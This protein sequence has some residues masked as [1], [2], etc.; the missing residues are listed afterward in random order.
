MLSILLDKPEI[1]LLLSKELILKYKL[2]QELSL[3]L[4]V[5]ARARVC[6]CYL[7][8]LSQNCFKSLPNDKFL[9]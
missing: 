4:C 8:G 9:D 2:Q 1:L 5:H 3:S 7:A 6:V